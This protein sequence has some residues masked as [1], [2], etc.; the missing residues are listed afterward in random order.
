MPSLVQPTTMNGATN[1]TGGQQY[2]TGQ[3]GFTQTGGVGVPPIQS[4]QMFSPQWA[5]NRW[6]V[7]IQAGMGTAT[8]VVLPVIRLKKS[9]SLSIIDVASASKS[10]AVAPMAVNAT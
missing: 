5:A 1:P 2:P 10:G 3:S 8:G 4:G 6:G 7:K 9:L